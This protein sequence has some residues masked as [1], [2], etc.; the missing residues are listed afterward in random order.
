[1]PSF[2]PP[3]CVLTA[4]GVKNGPRRPGKPRKPG[5]L[6]R[7]G[8]IVVAALL[9]AG[10]ASGGPEHELRRNIIAVIKSQIAA[11]QRNDGDMAFS[12]ASPD[13]QSQFGTADAFLARFAAAYK[14]VYRPKSVIFLNL[15]FSRGRLVQR[16]L[17][18]GPDGI[19]VIALFPMMQ[20]NDGSWRVDGY[21][22]VPATGKSVSTEPDVPV[23]PEPP[24]IAALAD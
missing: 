15:A 20:M 18:Q 16:V 12:Y 3:P 22:L 23:P 8:A 4:N 9:M 14:P 2:M 19:A 24:E 7:L 1:M 6:R 17:L 11:F 10:P 5:T 21:V 13:V